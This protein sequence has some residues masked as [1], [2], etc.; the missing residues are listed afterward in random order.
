MVSLSMTSFVIDSVTRHE[1][2][3]AQ[4]RRTTTPAA[5]TNPMMMS[6][7]NTIA[8]LRVDTVPLLKRGPITSSVISRTT[9]ADNT[10]HAANTE[11]PATAVK[12]VR[13]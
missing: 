5:R 7:P 9:T 13:L 8:T 2:R 4:V 1:V 10:V 12:N 11:A 3:P 6:V